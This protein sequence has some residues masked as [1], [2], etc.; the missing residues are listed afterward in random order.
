MSTEQ[1]AKL[2]IFE[3]HPLMTLGVEALIKQE[4]DFEFRGSSRHHENLFEE[5]SLTKPDALVIDL[6]LYSEKS[7]HFLR[8]LRDRF[9]KLK[10]ILLSIHTGREFVDRSV[11]GGADAYVL[12]TVDP[13]C[14]IE[15]IRESL[16]G[17]SYVSK[18]IRAPSREPLKLIDSPIN[19]LSAEEFQILQRIGKG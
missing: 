19:L 17:R 13:D 1:K 18:S 7:V 8:Q 5:L 4:S 16:A 12:K 14:I 10:I 3:E 11:E 6:S 9:L 2:F 15:A